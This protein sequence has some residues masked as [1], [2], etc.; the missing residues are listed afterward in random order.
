MVV[1][2][3]WFQNIQNQYYIYDN[4]QTCVACDVGTYQDVRNQ[5]RMC[6]LCSSI[7]NL[8]FT[9]TTGQTVC[10]QSVT[11]QYGTLATAPGLVDTLLQFG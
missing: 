7:G 4:K 2:T 1:S 8:Y 3:E 5:E 11:N 10:H 6:K 9:T